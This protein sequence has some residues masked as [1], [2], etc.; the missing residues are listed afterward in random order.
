MARAK[1]Y[2]LAALVGA[3]AIYFLTRSLRAP[4]VPPLLTP[5][6]QAAAQT[7]PPAARTPAAGMTG[8]ESL[9]TRDGLF[10]ITPPPNWAVAIDGAGRLVLRGKVQ[11]EPY[12]LALFWSATPWGVESLDAKAFGEWY[13]S[14]LDPTNELLWMAACDADGVPAMCGEILASEDDGRP[15]TA[16]VLFDCGQHRCAVYLESTR[17]V[18]SI[19][20][21]TWDLAK[22][23]AASVNPATASAKTVTP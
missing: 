4:A 17:P 23:V 19:S 21:A 13:K 1:W 11:E 22:R 18:D 20:Q 10:S 6:A 3:A 15:R 7:S 16:L 12:S 8:G 5:A 2:I 9:T 14:Q